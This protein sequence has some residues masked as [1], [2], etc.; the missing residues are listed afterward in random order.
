MHIRQKA[1]SGRFIPAV[2]KQRT[3]CRKEM[4]LCRAAVF[5]IFQ[6]CLLVVQIIKCRIAAVFILWTARGQCRKI[7][8]Y[9]IEIIFIL[10]ASFEGMSCSL[11]MD[12]KNVF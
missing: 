2:P 6:R 10:A 7:L 4:K 5:P 1:A 3:V 11:I 12:D 9:I 8:F